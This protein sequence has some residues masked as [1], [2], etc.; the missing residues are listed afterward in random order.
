MSYND[1][2]ISGENGI[3]ITL[4]MGHT[5]PLRIATDDLLYVP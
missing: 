2:R 5:I 3:K 4:L 1:M